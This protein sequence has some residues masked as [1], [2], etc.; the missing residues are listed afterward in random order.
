MSQI[1]LSPPPGT[2]RRRP[3]LSKGLTS[4]VKRILA[5]VATATLALGGLVAT[6]T[7][8]AAHTPNIDATCSNLS[9]ALTSYAERHGNKNTV[10]V[11]VDGE[12]VLEEEFG[13]AFHDTIALDPTQR[14]EWSVTVDA[15][16]DDRWDDTQS[17]T[18]RACD[19]GNEGKD[20]DRGGHGDKGHGKDKGRD[21]DDRDVETAFYVYPKIDPSKPAAWENSGEQTLITTREGDEFWEALP[22]EYPGDL[23]D[24]ATL[25][26]DVCEG[27]WGVQQDTVGI[28]RGFDWANYQHITYPDGPLFK[29]LRKHQHS[30]LADI[31]PECAEGAGEPVEL[32]APTPVESCDAENAVTL[33]ETDLATYE[34][35]WND[36]RTEASITATVAEGVDLAPEAPT[37]WTFTFT[38]ELC[39]LAP[40]PVVVTPELPTVTDLCGVENDDLVVPASTDEITYSSSPEGV[41]AT[42]AE[43]A[44]LGDLPEGYTAVDASSAVF[45]VDETLFTDEECALVPG[46]IGAICESD[47][48]YLAY[49]VSLPEGI[50]AEG[51]NP[52]TVTFLNPDGENH[53]TTDL[54]LEGRLLWPGASADEPKQW[55]G[56]ELVDGSY[57]ETDGNFAW[58]REGVQVLFEV[59]PDYATVVDY[60]EATADCANPP[61]DVLQAAQDVEVDATDVDQVAA[62]EAELPRTGATVGLAAAI[63]AL[64]LGAG[65]TLF[66][67]RR[68][69]QGR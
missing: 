20:K 32:P 7:S 4:T 6:A 52:L 48:P 35:T 25:T 63:A 10:T 27:S 1:T 29:D 55:P 66:L 53:V 58:T 51:D 9:V 69:L 26:A 23:F 8:A 17:G 64:L 50:E 12:T 28:H 13:A 3:T 34:V 31:L 67:V 56:W 39:E 36:D 45:A 61:S 49:A 5:S 21:K 62:T 40:E 44:T 65:A 37:S 57:V 15:W 59:N 24:V 42:V 18:S 46:D 14:Q 33:P 2:V 54:P 68:R 47:V 22:E 60:P 30:E 16:D 43:G 38:G 19:A 11:V 41:L